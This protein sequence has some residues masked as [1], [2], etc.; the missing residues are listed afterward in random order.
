MV[1]LQKFV[2]A[3]PTLC[4]VHGE[5]VVKA[6]LKKTLAQGWWGIISLFVAT[7]AMFR[8]PF[9]RRIKGV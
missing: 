1:V 2:R 3:K 8:G 7:E 9:G 6:F 5:Q 4:R